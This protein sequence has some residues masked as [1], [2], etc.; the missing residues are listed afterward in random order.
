M[1]ICIVS[2]GAAHGLIFLPVF[3]SYIGKFHRKKSSES[4]GF[5]LF[6]FSSSLGPS[7]NRIRRSRAES[8][9]LQKEIS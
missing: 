9:Q 7:R 6:V 2:F 5:L 1:F 3:L 4:N 8:I